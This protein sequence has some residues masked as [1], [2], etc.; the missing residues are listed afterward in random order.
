MLLAAAKPYSNPSTH[1]GLVYWDKSRGVIINSLLTTSIIYKTG[2][3]TWCVFG[4][5][6]KEVPQLMIR[7]PRHS[8]PPLLWSDSCCVPLSDCS[9]HPRLHLRRWSIFLLIIS[10]WFEVWSS[11]LAWFIFR[12]GYVFRLYVEEQK[13]LDPRCSGGPGLKVGQVLKR[14]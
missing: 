8:V 10:D 6:S 13:E 4:S 14:T 5:L 2:D 7:S 12:R 11:V 9:I 3:W 1:H